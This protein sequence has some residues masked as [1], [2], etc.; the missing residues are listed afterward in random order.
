MTSVRIMLPT[1]HPK[2]E[3]MLVPDKPNIDWLDNEDATSAEVRYLVEHS[4]LSPNQAQELVRQH[5]IDRQKLM[6]IARTRKAE[7]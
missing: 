5:G 4:D 6:S 2:I 1:V 7:S 3:N